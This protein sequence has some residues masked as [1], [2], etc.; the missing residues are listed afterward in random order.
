MFLLVANL[1]H[2]DELILSVAKTREKLADM[3]CKGTGE[4]EALE[5]L[6]TPSTV[7]SYL[8]HVQA[9]TSNGFTRKLQV[10]LEHLCN[11]CIKYTCSWPWANWFHIPS[12][13]LNP[14]WLLISKPSCSFCKG[15][16]HSFHLPIA[17][18]LQVQSIK[19]QQSGSYK[20]FSL[21]HQLKQTEVSVLHLR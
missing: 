3:F 7:L 8:R 14:K 4:P 6:R 18:W 1:R 16:Q 17:W 12:L 10:R 9:A 5:G 15:S 11:Q 2:S 21:Q 19:S 13:G 20:S